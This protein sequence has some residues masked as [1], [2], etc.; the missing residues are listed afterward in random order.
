MKHFKHL[1]LLMF[2]SS[3]FTVGFSQEEEDRYKNIRKKDYDQAD[4]YA[5]GNYPLPPRPK[6][7]WAIGVKGGWGFVAGDVS[8]RPGWA[9]GL[10]VR[11]GLGHAFSLRLALGGG[12]SFGQNYRETTGYRGHAGNPWHE[13]Y[14]DGY[15]NQVD[16]ANG[17]NPPSGS[18][19]TVFYNY[20]ATIFDATLQGIFNL[21][22][23]NFYK[24]QVKWNLYVGVGF[25]AMMYNTKVDAL[26]ANGNIYTHFDAVSGIPLNDGQGT[27][28]RADRID[29]LRD[30]QDQD[31]ETFAEGH[32]DRSA[33]T[34]GDAAFV[35]NPV[36]QGLAGISYRINRRIELNLEY[37]F[38]WSSDDLIDGNRWQETGGGGPDFPR[39]KTSLSPSSDLFNT[40][41]I[42]LGFRL[43]KGE[44]SP[45][46][47]NPVAEA[48]T[49]I[50]EAVRLVDQIQSDADGDG[51][52]DL[53]DKEPDTPEGYIVGSDGRVLDS[54]QDG[55]PDS[56]DDEPFSPKNC[57]VDENGVA[58]DSDN[59]GV[60]DCYDKE[61]NSPP[62]SYYDVNGVAIQIEPAD[63]PKDAPC[64][65]P[66]VHFDSDKDNIKPEFYPEMYYVAQVMKNDPGLKIKA[67]GHADVTAGDAY[68]LELSK[69]RVQNVVDFLVNTYGIDPN[70]FIMEYD[71]SR[72]PLIKN[73]PAKRQA[74]LEPLRY[75]NRRVEFECIRE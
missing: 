53:Y 33:I 24:E 12:Q 27:D 6:S 2:L 34:F 59:D 66:I 17:I 60:P 36:L 72:A 38:A 23:V 20:K 10:D 1:L 7:N 29:A 57:D 9:G 75:V 21:N 69:R 13:N 74:K 73:L 25:G 50:N 55:I 26:D 45:W 43:G 48:Y 3:I 18:P 8:T 22:N 32:V 31:Y 67:V 46:W 47:D 11:K 28:G 5:E 42:G 63:D 14:F 30:A 56:E 70:R 61:P 41:T 4:A 54:D 62:G 16:V 49:N 39:D 71:G 58:I 19:P 68:N 35:V 40:V 52:P 37:K 15:V 44:E 51:V 64:L 65:L